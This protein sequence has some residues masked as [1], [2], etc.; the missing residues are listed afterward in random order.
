MSTFVC[1]VRRMTVLR[2]ASIMQVSSLLMLQA[3]I[4]QNR[5]WSPPLTSLAVFS[6]M[7]PLVKMP[8]GKSIFNVVDLIA[9]CRFTSEYLASMLCPEAVL[10]DQPYSVVIDDI[11]FLGYPVLFPRHTSNRRAGVCDHQ[12]VYKSVGKDIHYQS[13]QYHCHRLFF[14]VQLPADN[15]VHM[16]HLCFV[17]QVCMNASPH[18]NPIA[19]ID[20]PFLSCAHTYT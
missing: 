13:T 12:H 1:T 2:M 6:G 19:T 8:C 3:F 20:I 9:L 15:C 10:C 18:M 11:H 5:W 17:L 7:W 16:F 14:Y 4:C